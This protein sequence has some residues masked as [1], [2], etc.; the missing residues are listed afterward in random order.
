M[1]SSSSNRRTA[2]ITGSAGQIGQKISE[3]LSSQG[4]HAIGLY[5]NQ[6]PKA[7]NNF[8]PLC[9]DLLQPDSAMAALKSTD[10]VIHLAWQGDVLGAPSLHGH[11]PSDAQIQVSSNVVM[12]QN[13]VRAMERSNA[14]KIVFL[15]WVGVDRSANSTVLREKYWAENIILNSSIPEKIIIR[16]GV[17]SGGL[18]DSGFIKAAASLAKM[19]LILPLPQKLGG[20]VLTTVQDI[21]L[22]VDDALK[23]KDSGS[24][25]R[26]ID[27]TSTEPLSGA[28]IISAM[29]SK[30]WGKRRLTIGGSIGDILFRWAESRFG[31]AK[32]SE[33]RLSDYF[34]AGTVEKKPPVEGVPPVVFGQERGQKMTPVNAL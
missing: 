33:P 6:L 19:P 25:C 11:Y 13:L 23:I 31:A 22:A 10:T 12:T 14:R 4:K 34:N 2:F 17:I 7:L 8:L 26:I 16:A 5:R 15:S 21:L 27:L 30:I 29:E 1:T 24:Y 3:H 9:G 32:S 18:S 28:A 20:V